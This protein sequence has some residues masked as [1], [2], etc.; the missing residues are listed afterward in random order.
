MWSKIKVWK[1]L[2]AYSSHCCPNNHGVVSLQAL[3]SCVLPIQVFKNLDGQCSSFWGTY[4]NVQWL[5]VDIPP[6]DLGHSG[7][8]SCPAANACTTEMKVTTLVPGP[9]TLHT[10]WTGWRVEGLGMRLSRLTHLTMVNSCM[11][12]NYKISH[13]HSSLLTMMCSCNFD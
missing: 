9:S 12:C 2:R 11:I 3:V 1:R 7:S 4:Y 8:H 10:T 5:M 6:V 13:K